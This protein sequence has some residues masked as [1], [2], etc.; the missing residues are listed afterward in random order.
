MTPITDEELLKMLE[1]AEESD[2]VVEYTN[3]VVPFLS[4]YNIKSGDERVPVKTLYK[5]YKVYTINYCDYRRFRNYITDIFPV[6]GKGVASYCLVDIEAMTVAKL[7]FEL[8]NEKKIGYVISDS[9]MRLLDNYLERDGLDRGDNMIEGFVLYELYKNHY[10]KVGRKPKWKVDTYYKIMKM[11]FDHST[12]NRRIWF[13][14]SN[15]FRE[16]LSLK[17]IENI[18]KSREKKRRSKS[19][20]EKKSK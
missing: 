12:K 8:A 13:G 19:K 9:N 4:K 15:A 6:T 1:S 10:K 3:N 2:E 16:S 17:D 14:V 7:Y 18:R 20:K 11:N 5:L